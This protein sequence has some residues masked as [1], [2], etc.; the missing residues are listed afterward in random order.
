MKINKRTR[1][2]LMVASVAYLFFSLSACGKKE[3]NLI[4][5]TPLECV[6]EWYSSPGDDRGFLFHENGQFELY[7]VK[8][9]E[10]PI[11]IETGMYGYESKGDF[12][13]V[14]LS[15]SATEYKNFP[16]SGQIWRTENE[17]ELIYE[18]MHFYRLKETDEN[19]VF[20][21]LKVA[22]VPMEKF[23][24]NWENDTIF[25][26]DLEIADDTYT[27]E[28]S[29]GYFTGEYIRGYDYLLINNKEM[30]IIE[31]GDGTL[32]VSGY[33]GLFYPAG[34]GNRPSSPYLSYV[35]V[36]WNSQ[37]QEQ[38]VIDEKGTFSSSKTL[39]N[40]GFT[41]SAG[42]LVLDGEVLTIGD[43]TGKLENGELI[44]QGVEGSFVKE[45]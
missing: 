19:E 20:M 7:R 1:R 26:I 16:I 3:V 38:F 5:V 35:G 32:S 36:W 44:F 15:D 28:T 33:D 25:G 10:I 45:E 13:I 29:N 21:S 40:D 14:N 27:L 6:G 4:Y 39:E 42:L 37:T 41:F 11:I 22:E 2:L 17:D 43:Y 30:K 8:P 24:G 31:N 18:D 23:I 9:G 34:S 12:G